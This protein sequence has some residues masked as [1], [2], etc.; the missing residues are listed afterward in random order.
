M[1]DRNLEYKFPDAQHSHAHSYLLPVVLSAVDEFKPV[2]IFDLGCG[3][4]STAAVLAK[5]AQ[6][7]GVDPSKEGICRANEA[8]PTLKLELGSAYDDLAEKYG[9]FDMVVSLEVVEHVY[10]PRRYARTLA[11]LLKPGGIAVISTPYHGYLKNLARAVTGKLDDHFT[12][13]WDGGHI[14]FW[15]IRTLSILLREAGLKIIRF[16][17]VGRVPQLA[18]SMVAVVRKPGR[19]PSN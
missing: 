6:V 12:A 9:T 15:S 7:M 5:S 17:R 14:K 18:K 3:N 2:R 19:D 1:T 10:D 4:G 13:L 8:Y 16:E 11:S